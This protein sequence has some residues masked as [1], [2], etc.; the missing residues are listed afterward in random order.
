M[1][2]EK[3][4]IDAKSLER[5]IKNAFSK[6]NPYLM[7][8]MLRWIRMQAKVDAVEVVH[9]RWIAYESD[10]TYGPYDS[11]EW[12]KCSNCGKDA[13]GRCYDDEWYS[14]PILSDYCPKCGAKM[15]GGN[16]E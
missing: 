12:H 9:A 5:Q 16:E 6:D 2:N 7:G 13:Y 11:K 15:D 10:E 14:S 3:R 1:V 4:L 8:Q